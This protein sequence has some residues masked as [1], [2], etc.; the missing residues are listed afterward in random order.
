[1]ACDSRNLEERAARR[2]A[3]NH[4][5]AP[6]PLHLVGRRGRSYLGGAPISLD[7]LVPE[8]QWR[9]RPDQDIADPPAEAPLPLAAKPRHVAV[10][11]PDHSFER[12]VLAADP[13]PAAEQDADRE[14]ER[15][16]IDAQHHKQ[17]DKHGAIMPSRQPGCLPRGG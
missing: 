5:P 15:D 13:D 17:R 8:Q 10:S 1:M 7:Q 14:H 9:L 3:N 4:G 11:D 6:Q 12:A 2:H 16:Q